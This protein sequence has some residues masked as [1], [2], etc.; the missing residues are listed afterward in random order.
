[1]GPWSIRRLML[2]IA[3]VAGALGGYVALERLY[4]MRDGCG[5]WTQCASNLR[6]VVLG[7]LGYANEHG[8]FPEGTWPHAGLPPEKRLSWYA[9]T[10]PYLDSQEY[11]EA[12]DREQSWDSPANTAISDARQPIL[13]CPEAAL[14]PAGGPFSASYIG[15]AGMGIDAPRLPKGHPRAGVFGYD[16]RTRLVDLTDGAAF[17]MVVAESGRMRGS[18]LSGGYATIRGLDTADQPYIGAGRQFGG[19]HRRPGMHLAFA[20]GAVRFITD[21]IDPK[22]FEAFCTIAGGEKLPGNLFDQ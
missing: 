20:D 15:I 1:M 2:V 17:T 22:I 19:L 9:A 18:W 4:P 21:T 5:R 7:A 16:R 12:L 11:W 8:Y 3:G 14:P 10:S 13:R 6:N